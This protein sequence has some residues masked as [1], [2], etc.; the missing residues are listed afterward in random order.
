MKR[1]GTQYNWSIESRCGCAH[2]NGRW[3]TR[4]SLSTAHSIVWNR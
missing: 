3:V 2:E 4:F 1:C